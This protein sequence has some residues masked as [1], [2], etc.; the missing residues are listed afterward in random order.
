LTLNEV[1]FTAFSVDFLIKEAVRS[2]YIDNAYSRPEGQ[3]LLRATVF[4]VAW[5][6]Q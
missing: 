5:L 3:S 6:K 1:P 2:N 4:E